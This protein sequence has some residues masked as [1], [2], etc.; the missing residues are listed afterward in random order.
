M[1][2]YTGVCEPN[3]ANLSV[4]PEIANKKNDRNGKRRQH[5]ALMQCHPTLLNKEQ[6]QEQQHSRERVEQSVHM[7]QWMSGKKGRQ[8]DFSFGTS[9]ATFLSEYFSAMHSSSTFFSRLHWLSLVPSSVLR[10][11][12]CLS[13]TMA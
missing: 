9:T 1:T 2:D 6:A 13:M 7:H 12:P 3:A 4:V 8:L 5:R 10:I 11:L